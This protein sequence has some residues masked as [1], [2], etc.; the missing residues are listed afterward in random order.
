MDTRLSSP[1]RAAGGFADVVFQ[2]CTKLSILFSMFEVTLV[3]PFPLNLDILS[4][5]RVMIKEIVCSSLANWIIYIW[6]QQDENQRQ[7]IKV[8]T[9]P[10]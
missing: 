4:I 1:L 5:Y 2:V 8:Y 3:P 10:V 6:K 9:Q 7:S